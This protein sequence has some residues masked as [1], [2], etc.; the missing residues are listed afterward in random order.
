MAL[1]LLSVSDF[2]SRSRLSSLTGE[3]SDTIEYWIDLAESLLGR[4]DLDQAISGFD[5]NMTFA[6]QK[7]TEYLYITND[8]ANVMASNSVFKSERIGSFSY[9]RFDND[10]NIAVG[11]RNIFD[12][13]PSIVAAIVRLYIRAV[14]PVSTTSPVFL[15]TIVDP[16][17]RREYQ[18]YISTVTDHYPHLF[19]K[20][21]S[22]W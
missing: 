18:D 22:L 20:A 1:E 7:Y 17:G 8:E 11:D 13:M 2:I 9:T 19:N 10:V 6:V 4:L 21:N 15:E 5:V 16:K 3:D 12:S 14:E